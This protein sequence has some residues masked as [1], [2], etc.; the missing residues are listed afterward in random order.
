MKKRKRECITP[1]TE[2]GIP[3][4]YL[5]NTKEGAHGSVDLQPIFIGSAVTMVG[6]ALPP[7]RSAICRVR[8]LPD[9]RPCAVYFQ[10]AFFTRGFFPGVCA[11]LREK[12]SIVELTLP[13]LAPTDFQC[14]V[15]LLC[16]CP[17][18]QSLQLYRPRFVFGPTTNYA[19]VSRDEMWSKSSRP[20]FPL[21]LSGPAQR[22]VWGR[23]LAYIRGSPHLRKITFREPNI[24]HPAVLDLFAALGEN[25]SLIEVQAVDELC[26][27]PRGY[28]MFEGIELAAS[29]T[30][31]LQRLRVG[32]ISP[33]SARR[34]FEGPLRRH[35][36]IRSVELLHPG[37]LLPLADAAHFDGMLA[38]RVRQ[39]RYRHTLADEGL[40]ALVEERAQKRT[41]RYRTRLG[42]ISTILASYRREA[43]SAASPFDLLPPE[44]LYLVIHHAV[45]DTPPPLEL[46]I[47]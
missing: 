18:I 22:E 5:K 10:G 28:A 40:R 43:P 31:T 6:W 45:A 29:R 30:S 1:S 3:F 37:A 26:E 13:H 41:E 46:K 11:A 9:D 34:L 21:E 42:A 2:E 33:A 14:F 23:F 17:N 44:I 7:V 38:S 20:L 24:P 47:T 32:W 27:S 12:K 4:L 16:E 15:D 19:A 36:S 8:E 39:I 35:P 25:R